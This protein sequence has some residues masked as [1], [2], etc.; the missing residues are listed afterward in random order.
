M[1]YFFLTVKFFLMTLFLSSMFN[2]TLCDDR[3][4]RDFLGGPVGKTPSSQCWGYGF[5]PWLELRS[6]TPQS[7][8]K[9]KKKKSVSVLSN[10]VATSHRWLLSIWS[11]TKANEE[12]N[13]KFYLVST[14]WNVNS[15]ILLVT[16]ILHNAAP[17]QF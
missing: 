10:M 12:P 4:F 11:I 3:Y 15:H 14:R 13:F 16:A 5:H 2:R 1:A 17:Y 8:A 7:T 6:C 9:K